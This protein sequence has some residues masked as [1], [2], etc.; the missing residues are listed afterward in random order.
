MYPTILM[1]QHHYRQYHQGKLFATRFT[2]DTQLKYF[3][4][5][6]FNMECNIVAL[7][8]TWLCDPLIK[9]IH[10]SEIVSSTFQIYRHERAE[11]GGSSVFIEF[12][13]AC[14]KL[15]H[16]KLII[17]CSYICMYEYTSSIQYSY[18]LRCSNKQL[19]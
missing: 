17:K 7:I 11:K 18:I 8:E 2:Q 10:N 19:L 14:I 5:K 6:S 4:L 9:S 1:C 16:S 13:T 3:F 12:I 15:Q